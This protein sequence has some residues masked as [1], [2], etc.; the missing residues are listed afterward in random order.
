MLHKEGDIWTEK[1]KTWTVKNG[2]KR[3][4]SKFSKVRKDIQTPLCCPK[5]S[6]TLKHVDEKFYKFNNVCMDC[7]IE[8]EHELVKQGKYK[9]YEKA[10]ILANAK[11]YILDMDQFFSEYIQN[12]I[13]QSFVTEDGDV[14]RW[15]GNP[16]K[17]VEE[18][19]KPKIDELKEQIIK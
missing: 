7:T 6:K 4:V 10:R 18:I 9:D 2:V 13:E 17:K 8:F 3:T 1:G 15:I 19:V 16:T 5:C 12:T 14:E 11:G